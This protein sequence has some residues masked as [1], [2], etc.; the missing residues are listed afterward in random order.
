[1]A[2]RN[3]V[4]VK[5]LR[6]GNEKDVRKIVR[7]HMAGNLCATQILIDKVDPNSR[8]GREIYMELLKTC[9]QTAVETILHKADVTTECGNDLLRE[10]ASMNDR[11]VNS[12]IVASCNIRNESCRSL[13][14]YIYGMSDGHLRLRIAEMANPDNH[15]GRRFIEIHLRA[16]EELEKGAGTDPSTDEGG[17]SIVSMYESA[18]MVGFVRALRNVDPNTERG[19]GLLRRLNDMGCRSTASAILS[20]ADPSAGCGRMCM[21]DVALGRGNADERYKARS[22]IE[23]WADPDSE[24]DMELVRAAIAANP[25]RDDGKKRRR[26]R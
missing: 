19:M 22:I 12:R 5:N 10:L 13:L 6:P 15:A 2:Y 14:A 18:E 17:E 25:D 16:T 4:E 21:M 20:R 23:E 24:D 11:H 3:D 7:Y 8:I 1:M 9:D 26:R